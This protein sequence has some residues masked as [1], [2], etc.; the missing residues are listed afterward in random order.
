[1]V[2]RIEQT[3]I[4]DAWYRNLRDLRAKF[5]ITR[6]IDNAE[7]G[8][9]GDAKPVGEGISEMRVHTGQ[10]VPAVFHNT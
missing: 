1:M 8:L 6:R 4:F 2:Y 5:A 3:E 10:G 9:F 7:S